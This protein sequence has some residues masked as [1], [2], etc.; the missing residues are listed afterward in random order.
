MSAVPRESGPKPAPA[1][2]GEP[3]AAN[4]T[5][6]EAREWSSLWRAARRFRLLERPWV[7]AA[8]ACAVVLAALAVIPYPLTVTAE[9]VVLPSQ[10]RLVRAAMEGVL[11]EIDAE[12]G[13][14]VKAGQVLARLDARPLEADAR[15]A[16]AEIARIQANLD[17]LRHGARAEEIARQRALVSAR[18]SDAAFAK[19]ELERQSKLLEKGFVSK[20]GLESYERDLK[21]KEGEADEARAQLK[22]LEVGARP[23]EI[24][25]LEAELR[26]AQAELVLARQRLEEMAVIKAPIDGVVV[27]PKFQE[28][29]HEK[30][31]AGDLVCELAGRE[32]MRAEIAVPERE[33]D[34]IQ[35][36]LPVV[37]KVAAY[38]SVAFEGAVTLVGA[39]VEPRLGADGVVRVVTE[40]ADP[41]GLLR[42]QMSG[43]GEIRAPRQSLLSL[44]T[45]RLVRWVRVRFL[46]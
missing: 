30:V 15:A 13:S 27:T 14:A 32:R 9:C 36:G 10:R 11:W 37:V 34:A 43:Y 41:R 42:P 38:P 16:E 25:A 17:R 6:D 45:R 1:G 26:R 19:A 5:P 8:L 24:A 39:Q 20:E 40:I 23:E 22:L 2:G 18:E 3:S 12:E 21:V 33:L 29:L 7:R 46:I 44:A 35:V 4:D 31:A 28:R